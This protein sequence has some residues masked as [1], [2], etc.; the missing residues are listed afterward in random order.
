MSN[1]RDWS[2]GLVLIGWQGCGVIAL[3]C[4]A[5]LVLFLLTR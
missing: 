4:L 3:V 2:S 5:G 1:P